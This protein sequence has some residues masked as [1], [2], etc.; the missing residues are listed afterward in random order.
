[1]HRDKH[2][3][4]YSKNKI[5]TDLLAVYI[6]MIVEDIQFELFANNSHTYKK[7]KYFFPN[8]LKK[9]IASVNTN[10]V[11]TMVIVMRLNQH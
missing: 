5:Q 9:P 4:K 3:L 2:V 11:Q 6:A 1:M 7:N 8:I 10:N